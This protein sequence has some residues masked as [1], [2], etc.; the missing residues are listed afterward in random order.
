MRRFKKYF[1]DNQWVQYAVAGCIV[2]LFLAG[3]NSLSKLTS[4]IGNILLYLK[5]V[6][7]GFMVAYISDPLVKIMEIRLF[8]KIKSRNIRR[9]A[10]V[11]TM[12]IAVVGIIGTIT[13]LIVPQVVSSVED[14]VNNLDTYLYTI[15]RSVSSL[16]GI[17]T[18]I[19]KM[20]S[21]AIEGAKS[22]LKYDEETAKKVTDSIVQTGEG[23][24]NLIISVIIAAYVLCDK[25]KILRIVTA[26]TRAVVP[27]EK[28]ARAA[29][30]ITKCNEVFA[31]YLAGTVIDGVIIGTVTF[32]FLSLTGMEYVSLVSVVAGITNLAPIFGPVAGGLIGALLLFTINPWHA[33][34]Y[35]IFAVVIQTVD[36][37]YI[38][39]RLF[40]K[41][42]GI[43]PLWILIAIVVMGR[44]FG[45]AGVLLAIPIAAILDIFVKEVLLYAMRQ[46]CV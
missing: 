42:F 43:S 16:P 9:M 8:Y 22:Q 38:K 19:G 20:L 30:L 35:V 2:V 15:E 1:K 5:P 40:G 39:P 25:Y 32:A 14:I 7:M 11:W 4:I 12:I 13:A 27:C 31:R 36:G 18:D 26:V 23:A 24:A 3:L 33:F 29:I 21:K 6:L 44:A 37:Y 46:K 34:W 28:H 17:M 10:A 41:A 45:L